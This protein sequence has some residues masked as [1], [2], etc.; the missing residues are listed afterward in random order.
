MDNPVARLRRNADT[1]EKAKIVDDETLLEL[2]EAKENALF[3]T[4]QAQEADVKFR[5]SLARAYR[6]VGAPIETSMLCLVCGMIRHV[7]VGQCP[8]CSR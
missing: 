3:V 8:R 7:S 2:R 6:Q 5:A 4:S 1:E